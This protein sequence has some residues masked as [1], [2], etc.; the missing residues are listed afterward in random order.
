MVCPKV[1][2]RYSKLFLC[3]VLFSLP[4]Q[5]W[6]LI[7]N[8]AMSD[9]YSRYDHSQVTLNTYCMAP[10][11]LFPLES[12]NPLHHCWAGLLN[13]KLGACMYPYSNLTYNYNEHTLFRLLG[14][15]HVHWRDVSLNQK[16]IGRSILYFNSG[17]VCRPHWFYLY[18]TIDG[19]AFYHIIPFYIIF[20]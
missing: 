6:N 17:S 16:I 1:I 14:T 15:K 7:L 10:S 13:E 2:L 5:I 20:S 11:P 9:L 8:F 18:E 19:P 3:I 12:L 4:Y